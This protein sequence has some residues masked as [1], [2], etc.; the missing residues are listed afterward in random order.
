MFYVGLD[1]GQAQ[2]FTALAVIEKVHNE[3]EAVEFERFSR[4]HRASKLKLNEIQYLNELRR[5][6]PTFH[7]LR[8]IDRVPLGTPYPVIIEMVKSLVQKDALRGKA[9]LVVDATGCGRPIVDEIRKTRLPLSAIL[10]TGGHRVNYA[11]GYIHVPKRELVSMLQLLL[12]NNR[13]KFAAD[14]PDIKNLINELL[15]F[16]LTISENAHDTYEG[17]QGVHDDLVLAVA[18]AAWYSEI[19]GTAGDPP[20]QTHYDPFGLLKNI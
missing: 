13:L 10:I 12:G 7:H 4:L 2:D 16:Q 11:D 6:K 20:I 14:L 18:L 19:H 1:L 17:R 5:T 8:H 3:A 9:Y 15:N